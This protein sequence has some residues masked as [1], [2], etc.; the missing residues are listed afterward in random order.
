MDNT[1]LWM[2]SI[3]KKIIQE[4]FFNVFNKGYEYCYWGVTLRLSLEFLYIYCSS[5][6]KLKIISLYIY[7]FMSLVIC[8]ANVRSNQYRKY[9]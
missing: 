1:I 3:A 6:M 5:I 7:N 4:Q 9:H 2:N 8:L